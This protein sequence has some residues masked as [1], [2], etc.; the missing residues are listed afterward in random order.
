MPGG[1]VDKG[2]I[3]QQIRRLTV[4]SDSFQQCLSL[5]SHMERARLKVDSDLYPPMIAGVAVTYAKNFN[6]ADGLGPLPDFFTRFPTTNLRIAHAK[7]IEARNQV[8]AHRDARAHMFTNDKGQTVAYPVEVTINDEEFLLRTRMVE[9]PD[10]RLPVI[11][12]LV[13]FQMRR[14]KDDLDGK[15]ALVVDFA[16]GYERGRVYWL[17][18]D[19]P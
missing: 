18:D 4:A 5:L 15:L 6:D 7:L 8:Y 10:A 14:L 19:F 13:E 11:R 3:I 9:I 12:E 2:K 1:R 16:K 17:G